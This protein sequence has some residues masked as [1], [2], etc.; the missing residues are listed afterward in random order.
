[1]QD[2]EPDARLRATEA[3]VESLLRCL[4][5]ESSTRLKTTPDPTPRSYAN[6]VIQSALSVSNGPVHQELVEAIR[7]FVA[8]LR[9]TPHGKRILQKMGGGSGGGGGGGGGG[10]GG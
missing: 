8:S 10:K 2:E 7:P 4:P 1:V 6:Y 5:T 3:A 9:G